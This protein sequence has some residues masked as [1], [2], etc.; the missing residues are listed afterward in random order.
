VKP[1]GNNKCRN[2]AKI[3][4]KSCGKWRRGLGG[5]KHVLGVAVGEMI[6]KIE[7]KSCWTQDLLKVKKSPPKN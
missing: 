7:G 2:K 6:K 4:V 3:R 1:K 5:T